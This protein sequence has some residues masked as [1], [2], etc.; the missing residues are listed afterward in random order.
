MYA[1][2]DGQAKVLILP[3]GPADEL[4]TAALMYTHAI[5]TAKE[6]IWIA[7]PY[8]VPDEGVIH[9]LQLAAL[10][11]VDIRLLIPDKSDNRMV[12]LAAASY[13]DSLANV[14]AKFYRYTDGFLHEKTM[15]IDDLAAAVGTANFDNRSFRLNF[16]ITAIVAEPEFIEQMEKMFEADFEKSRLMRAGEYDD[17]PFWFRFAVRL[18][19]LTAPIQ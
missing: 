10:R 7:S 14:G 11:G 15:I 19:S 13:F 3:S 8:F 5:N 17:K 9:A 4:E 2:K 6:R 1:A 18:S 12:D 16:E